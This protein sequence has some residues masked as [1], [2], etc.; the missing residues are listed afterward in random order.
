MQ[1]QFGLMYVVYRLNSTDLYI[2]CIYLSLLIK[3][4]QIAFTGILAFKVSIYRGNNLLFF[5]SRKEYLK[6][7]KTIYNI[8]TVLKMF[9]S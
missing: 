1:G 6:Y 8:C 9:S 3:V 5:Q 2:C 4:M 7:E